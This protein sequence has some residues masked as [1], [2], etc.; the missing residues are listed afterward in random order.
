MKLEL[1]VRI[2]ELDDVADQEID[3]ALS[4]AFT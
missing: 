2:S 1:F 4:V 3:L